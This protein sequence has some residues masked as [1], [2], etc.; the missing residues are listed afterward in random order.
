MSLNR[1]ALRLATIA[2][3]TGGG[4]NPLYPTMAKD[5][6]Y[7]T[8]LD[9][10]NETQVEEIEPTI[11]IYTEVDEGELINSNAQLP[12][13]KRTIDLVIE[14]GMTARVNNNEV[15]LPEGQKAQDYLLVY[16]ETDS[17]LEAALDLFEHQIRAALT[18]QWAWSSLLHKQVT[19]WHGD[20]SARFATTEGGVRLAMR[21]FV[22]PV[23]IKQNCY[24]PQGATATTGSLLENAS[25]NLAYV[26]SYIATNG[27]QANG[28]AQSASALIQMLIG[29]L[30]QTALPTAPTPP[31]TGFN[32]N[33]PA[34]PSAMSGAPPNTS[35]V[36]AL[37]GQVNL[38]PPHRIAP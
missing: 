15:G 12:S 20:K 13:Y 1:L 18:T 26:L 17:E 36:F 29:H 8:R 16:P 14:F 6:V 3:L 4:A 35:E 11:I 5:R 7:D 24:L 28:V 22:M 30:S 27:G 21:R 2:C 31:L 25:S 38:P 19:K 32:I 10:L 37:Q 33:I 9:P 34:P 23:M